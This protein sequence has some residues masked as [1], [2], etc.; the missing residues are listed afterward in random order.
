MSWRVCRRAVAGTVLAAFAVAGGVASAQEQPTQASTS[1]PTVLLASDQLRAGDRLDFTIDGFEGTSV[2]ISVCGNGALRGSVDCNMVESEGLRLDRDGNSTN[3]S[4][5][6]AVPPAPCPCIVRVS[7]SENTQI[8]VA[9]L[10]IIDHPVAPLVPPAKFVQ[11]LVVTV[12]AV[13]SPASLSNRLRSSAGGRTVYDVTV[14]V[15]NR[16]TQNVTGVRV[17]GFGGRSTNDERVTLELTEPGAIGPGQTW[18]ETV[19]TAVPAPVW[20]TF[21]W[22]A[23][24][25]G[26]GPSVIGATTTSQQPWLLILLI[27]VLVIDALILLVRLVQRLRRRGDLS[28]PGSG[29]AQFADFPGG[30]GS[31]QLDVEAAVAAAGGVNR[32]SELEAVS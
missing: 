14:N 9:P 5:P 22:Q 12:T 10:V 30:D 17:S 13:E 1:G 19:L 27:V 6:V 23:T 18:T 15:R 25:S 21:H 31:G 32:E 20:G 28:D 7:D 24:A 4:V 8:A 11:P 29:G 26:I 3:S 2:I 16:S